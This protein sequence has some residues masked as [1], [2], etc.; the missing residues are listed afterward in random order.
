MDL[1]KLVH[2]RT[3]QLQ[4]QLPHVWRPPQTYWNL[5]TWLPFPYFQPQLPHGNPFRP[6]QTCSHLLVSGR[7]VF[8]W[9]AFLYEFIRITHS[10]FTGNCTRPVLPVFSVLSGRSCGV[11]LVFINIRHVFIAIN[12]LTLASAK[13]QFVS[14]L[15]IMFSN[16][17]FW[18]WC[19]N[20][21]TVVHFFKVKI[22][23]N[24]YPKHFFIF[25]SYMRNQHFCS[26][27]FS[28]KDEGEFVDKDRKTEVEKLVASQAS[29]RLFYIPPWS[30]LTIINLFDWVPLWSESSV[31]LPVPI[32]KIDSNKVGAGKDRASCKVLGNLQAS[33]FHFCITLRT[34]QQSGV[35]GIHVY[36][37]GSAGLSERHQY[38]YLLDFVLQFH[39][40]HLYSAYCRSTLDVLVLTVNCSLGQAMVSKS[41]LKKESR[42]NK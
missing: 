17:F 8:D 1:F 9:K 27:T 35:S 37:S 13:F 10:F 22:F 3:L 20:T 6:I 32:Q 34:E 24:I 42:Q 41:F 39:T 4:P 26:L 36:T 19:G 5:F 11:F 15:L 30:K 7:L 16:F 38:N 2:C 28:V 29:H 33:S 12:F 18:N 21:I 25:T 40:A 14:V 31:Y 23:K